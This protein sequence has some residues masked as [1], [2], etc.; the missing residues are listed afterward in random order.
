MSVTLTD[1]QTLLAFKAGRATRRAG[2]NFVDASPTKGAIILSN[3]EDGLLRFVWKDR[4]TGNV[5]EDLILFPG[6]ATFEKVSQAPGGRVYVLKFESSNQRH[7]FW[8][9]VIF[10]AF[11]QSIVCDA[12]G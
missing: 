7:F 11:I 3:S 8:L 9:Q 12:D 5:E 2:T 10:C 4:T 1:A 6:D